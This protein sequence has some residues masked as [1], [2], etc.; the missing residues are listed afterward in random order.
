M[1]S[2]STAR[3]LAFNAAGT[4]LVTAVTGGGR[5]PALYC[6]DT[7]T[8]KLLSSVTDLMAQNDRLFFYRLGW[9]GNDHFLLA[10]NNG[11]AHVYRATDGAA[12]ATLRGGRIA[13][14][15]P[16]ERLWY[17]PVAAGNATL[18]GVSFPAAL[19]GAAPAEPYALTLGP[20]GLL[21][22]VPAAAPPANAPPQKDA[23]V[24]PQVPVEPDPGPANQPAVASFKWKP[25]MTLVKGQRISGFV[26]TFLDAKRCFA[27][28]DTTVRLLSVSDRAMQA[29]FA[30]AA[31]RIHALAVS[32]DG[33]RMATADQGKQ[34]TIWDVATHEVLHRIAAPDVVHSVAFSPGG[35][36][37]A[38]GG[39]HDVYLWDAAT[40]KPL[41]MYTPGDNG[42]WSKRLA[43]TPD[44]R[45]LAIGGQLFSVCNLTTGKTD[46][47]N[48]AMGGLMNFAMSRGG[49]VYYLATSY[50]HLFR[51]TSGSLQTFKDTPRPI[52]DATFTADYQ[53]VL[54]GGPGMVGLASPGSGKLL[55][56]LEL[57]DGDYWHVVRSPAVGRFAA[58]HQ[59]RKE[60]YFVEIK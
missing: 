26:A 33:K 34:V 3:L 45:Q 36:Q 59:G 49:D 23:A 9:F 19:R 13:L 41:S 16:D 5:K 20:Q 31:G 11:N 56:T 55:S 28:S 40:G 17:C 60:S 43:F 54:V 14:H 48:G 4:R 21:G 57:P 51:K 15:A 46:V 24:F 53:A 50:R 25:K 6:Y 7:A 58:S 27:V 42:D 1:V 39:M 12:M 32:P 29:T 10:R 47:K 22:S 2:R 30:G 44:G 37:I 35:K 38:A 18:I 52:Y 8:G